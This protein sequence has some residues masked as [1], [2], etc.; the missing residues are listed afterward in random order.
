[1]GVMRRELL[2]T[3]ALSILLTVVLMFSIMPTGLFSIT[4]NAYYT[5][6]HITYEISNGKAI[7]VGCDTAICG[8]VVI[9]IA[10]F[11]HAAQYNFN[12]F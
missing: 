8:D 10:H 9:Q 2:F 12:M 6:D 11:A 7:I 1:M 3:M 5:S 4:A